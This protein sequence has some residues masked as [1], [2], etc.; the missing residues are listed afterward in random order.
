M[1]DK[2]VK[3]FIKT[4]EDGSQ[5]EVERGV[6]IVEEFDAENNEVKVNFDLAEYSGTQFIRLIYSIFTSFYRAG[7]FVGIIDDQQ[8]E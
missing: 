5:E 7:A 4:Y 2:M 8:E 3:G 1:E 6:L